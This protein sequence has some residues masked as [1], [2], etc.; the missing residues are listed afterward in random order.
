MRR[1]KGALLQEGAQKNLCGKRIRFY[2]Q[3]CRFSRKQTV[4]MLA[5]YGVHMGVDALSGIEYG[6]R[7]LCDRELWAFSKIFGVTVADVLGPEEDFPPP[8]DG[9]APA[10]DASDEE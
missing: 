5:P 3:Y 4:A 8:P 10:A 2:R 6:S 7:R 1:S 9:D